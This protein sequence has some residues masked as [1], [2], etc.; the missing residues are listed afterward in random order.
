[1]KGS[2]N[3]TAAMKLIAFALRPEVQAQTTSALGSIPANPKVQPLIDPAAIKY[4]PT[5]DN[6]KVAMRSN[7]EWWAKN[8]MSAYKKY[9]NWLTQ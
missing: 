1:M 4:Q 6:L 2:K 3:P 5:P 7:I 9:N 8:M